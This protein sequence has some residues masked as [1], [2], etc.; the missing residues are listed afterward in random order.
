[1]QTKRPWSSF[2]GLHVLG[3]PTRASALELFSR[4]SNDNPYIAHSL[5]DVNGD[6]S[7]G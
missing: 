1:M 2:Q 5:R 4:N 3:K 6:R 7:L